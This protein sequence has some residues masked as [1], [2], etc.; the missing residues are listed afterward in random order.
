M[1]KEEESNFDQ[2]ISGGGCSQDDPR[3]SV[4]E[5]NSRKTGYD[6]AVGFAQLMRVYPHPRGQ[7]E[8]DAYEPAARL[9]WA[10]LSDAQRAE[11]L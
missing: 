4:T 6:R 3:P 7:R 2:L 5:G 1:A 8:H 11:A 10:A 9:A